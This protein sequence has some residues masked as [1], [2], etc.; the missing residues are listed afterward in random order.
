MKKEMLEK[1]KEAANSPLETIAKDGI[2]SSNLDYLYKLI[3]IQK[4]IAN[5]EYWKAKEENFMRYGEGSYGRGNYGRGGYGNYGEYGAYGAYGEGSYGRRGN[6][7]GN[8]PEDKMD[9]MYM[10]YQAYS[11]GKEA[12]G[13]SG[14]Y[15][16]KEDS[17]KGLEKML[18]SAV[19]FFKMLKEEASSQEE[20]ELV[21]KYAKK[22]SEM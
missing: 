20:M 10:N 13:R 3:D 21:H 12:Y 9:E 15:S 19:D 2:S 11:E 18:E 7:R 14:N 16:A 17:M 5:I 6:F 22:I 8:R 4:D 1:I